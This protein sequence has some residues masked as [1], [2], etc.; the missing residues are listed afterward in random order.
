MTVE[1]DI[2]NRDGALEPGMYPDVRWQMAVPYAT[3][4]APSQAV[5]TA[6]NG[7][8]FVVRLDGGI[9]KPTHVICKNSMQDLI[10]IVGD[11]A[12]GDEIAITSLHELK[13]G[14]RVAAERV[15]LDEALKLSTKGESQGH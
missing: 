9:A 10:E 12:V 1:A 8:N 6:G 2:D 4:F 3:I 11:V 7:T 5:A 13:E 14:S 15:S